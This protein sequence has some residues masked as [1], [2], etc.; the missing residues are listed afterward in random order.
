[1][2]LTRA[3]LDPEGSAVPLELIRVLPEGQKEAPAPRAAVFSMRFLH[4]NRKLRGIGVAQS[5][6]NS[7]DAGGRDPRKGTGGYWLVLKA[8]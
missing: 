6:P 1:M 4:L 7:K 3:L 2:E 8:H 5:E